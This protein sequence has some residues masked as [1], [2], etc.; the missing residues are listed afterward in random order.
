MSGTEFQVIQ[1][2]LFKDARG[3]FFKPFSAPTLKQKLGFDFRPAETFF[4]VSNKNVLRGFHFQLPPWDL[5]KIV[6]CLKGRILDVAVDLR[7]NSPHYGQTKDC[8]LDADSGSALY[9]PKGFGHAFLSLEDE[10]IV[11]Y[12]T[13][14]PHS[15]NHDSGILWSSVNYPWP[16][17]NP[18]VSDRDKLFVPLKD[19]QSPF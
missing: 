19:F 12:L 14:S 3:T 16:V 17:E 13:D 4:S 10:T 2:P 1:C 6:F 9:I 15:P 8:Q 11:G 18:L 5:G 7:K